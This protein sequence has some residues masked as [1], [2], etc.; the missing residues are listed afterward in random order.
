MIHRG[1]PQADRARRPARR[2]GLVRPE[3]PRGRVVRRGGRSARRSAFEGDARLLTSTA[4]TSRCSTPGEPNSMY[5]G[6]DDQEEL[7][8]PLRRVHPDRRG[9]GAARCRRWDFVALSALHP[10]TSFVGAGDGPC[11]SLM[12]GGRRGR[13]L[14]EPADGAALKH[15]AG[16]IRG[17][18]RRV[19]SSRAQVSPAGRVRRHPLRDGDLPLARG[20][21]RHVRPDVRRRVE[22]VV[23]RARRGQSASPS[24]SRAGP[25]VAGRN[26]LGV[27]V[28]T[29][30]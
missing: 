17:D 27:D 6:E 16:V 1:R 19:S 7:P 4:S 29:S 30:T 11:A 3:R 18:A 2:R 22:D 10:R 23:P 5:H 24:A 8:R 9:R 28:G 21:E 15:D 13:Q 25:V 20:V 14:H 12:I 26:H